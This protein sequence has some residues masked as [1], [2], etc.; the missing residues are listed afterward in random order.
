MSVSSQQ[1][2]HPSYFTHQIVMADHPH[3]KLQSNIQYV[4]V[5]YSTVRRTVPLYVFC[6]AY[7]LDNELFRVRVQNLSSFAKFTS[8]TVV[9][10]NL[11]GIVFIS[12]VIKN[13]T[14]ST[15]LVH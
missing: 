1:Q 13:W 8:N 2:H 4:L 5:L 10:L 11:E 14:T 15:V 12:V 7:Q 3:E 9:W 6:E